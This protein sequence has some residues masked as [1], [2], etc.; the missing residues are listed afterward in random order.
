MK[1]DIPYILYPKQHIHD[2]LNAEAVLENSYF[3]KNI[4]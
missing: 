4:C 3:N 1:L 2:R